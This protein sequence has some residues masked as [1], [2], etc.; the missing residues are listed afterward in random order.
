M[1]VKGDRIVCPDGHLRTVEGMAPVPPGESAHVIVEGGAR[2]RAETCLRANRTD[3]VEAHRR[4]RAAAARVRTAPDPDDPEWRGALDELGRALDFLRTADPVVRLALAED[5]ARAAAQAVHPGAHDFH[6][7]HRSGEDT[8]SGWS[9]RTGHGSRARYGVVA[10]T[11][12]VAPVG[13]YEYRTT[14]ER[15]FLQAVR[16]DVT[17]AA[18]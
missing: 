9:F 11:A 8:P 1:F 4:C 15:A 7:V 17:C 2:W 13:L 14:A 16:T 12:E 18:G 3:I 5:D 6:P 10:L